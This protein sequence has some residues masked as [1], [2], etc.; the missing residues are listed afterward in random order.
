[1]LGFGDAGKLGEF[2]HA[3]TRS[4]AEP[5]QQHQQTAG[6]AAAAAAA[7]AMSQQQRMGV[8]VPPGAGPGQQL[9]VQTP[10]APM[11]IVI[12]NGVGPGDVVEFIMPPSKK[13]KRDGAAC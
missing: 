4:P 13:A 5:R 1:V 3:L 10:A 6:A 8:T 11:T 2:K 9:E 12:P 7:A